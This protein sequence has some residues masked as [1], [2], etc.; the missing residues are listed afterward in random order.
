MPIKRTESPMS[1]RWRKRRT[2]AD[3]FPGGQPVPIVRVLEEKELP[4]VEL[5]SAL[6]DMP[7][8]QWQATLQL[9]IEGKYKAE[10]MLRDERVIASPTLTAYYVGWV[11][12]VDFVIG[13]FESL[14]RG[15]LDGRAP[16]EVESL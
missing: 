14:R 2:I 11:A 15:E 10:S 8:R 16:E 13:S 1:L 12:Y 3:D 6:R 9:L 4:G 7:P 5:V